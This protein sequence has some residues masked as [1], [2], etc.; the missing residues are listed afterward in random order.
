MTNKEA[1][2]LLDP[3]GCTMGVCQKTK[4]IKAKHVKSLIGDGSVLSKFL[5]ATLEGNEEI[6]NDVMICIGEDGDA[7]QQVP[8]KLL[9]KYA[10]TSIDKEGWLICE[11]KPDVEVNYVQINE[12]NFFIFGQWGEVRNVDGTERKV[13]YGVQGDYVLQS[14]SD[15]TDFWIVRQRLFNATYEKK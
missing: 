2:K 1:A 15:S 4:P 14:Q 12:D 6:G 13:Q 5:V 11:P 7:W 10:V 8:K 9:Q 3:S